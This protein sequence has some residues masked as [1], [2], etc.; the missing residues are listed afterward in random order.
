MT[1]LAEIR[2]QIET[3]QKEADDLVK[4]EKA[5]IIQEIK[6]HIVDYQISAAD[7]GFAP[8]PA[9]ERKAAKKAAAE[10]VVKYRNDSG[11]TWSGGRGRRPQWVKDLESAGED[12]E[13]YRVGE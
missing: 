11:E 5:S 10:P 13:R 3:L 4:R 7:L 9:A 6:Q 2:K 12:I 8:P 1:T